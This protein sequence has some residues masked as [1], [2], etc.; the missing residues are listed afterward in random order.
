MLRLAV[1]LCYLFSAWLLASLRVAEAGEAR[2][3]TLVGPALFVGGLGLAVHLFLLIRLVP[4]ATGP[5]LSIPNVLSLMGWQIAAIGLIAAA[6]R[7]FRGLG[8]VLLPLAGLTA[9]AS[10][11]GEFHRSLEGL[12][13]E[14]K[15]H[16]LISVVA[17][18]LLSVGALIALLIAFQDRA[19]R[20]RHPLRLMRVL[21]PL[22]SMEQ[23][24]FATIHA[25]VILLTLS[26][27]S[28]LIFVDNIF[29]QHLVHK[30]LLSILALIVFGILL[31]GRWRLGWRGRTAIRWT[32]TGYVVLALAYFGTRVVLEVILN[33]Q[34]G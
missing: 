33:R 9:L 17:Y 13:W 22:E 21:P 3:R 1:L 16:I 30:T 10:G 27:F 29:A 14:M 7:R 2:G 15:S 31:V 24:L 20:A 5:D 12:G 26:V 23:V 18:T 11:L 34:W 8:A 4:T 32:L 25:G 19:L 28:G 6:W